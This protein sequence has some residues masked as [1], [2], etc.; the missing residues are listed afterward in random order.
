MGVRS[1][2]LGRSTLSPDLLQRTFD[3]KG[4]VRFDSFR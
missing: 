2:D 1:I 4:Q 3:R